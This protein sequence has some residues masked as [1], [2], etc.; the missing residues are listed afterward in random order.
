MPFKLKLYPCGFFLLGFCG[1]L[2]VGFVSFTIHYHRRIGQM[3]LQLFIVF[4]YLLLLISAL[5]FGLVLSYRCLPTI[6]E[7]VWLKKH[8]QHSVRALFKFDLKILALVFREL[9]FYPRRSYIVLANVKSLEVKL[10]PRPSHCVTN[11]G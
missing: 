9:L 7:R 4:L 11:G 10:A 6:F 2:R 1:I 8:Q 3:W 5:F